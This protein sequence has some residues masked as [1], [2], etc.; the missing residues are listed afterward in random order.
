MYEM[1]VFAANKEGAGAHG[2]KPKP[3]SPEARAIAGKLPSPERPETKGDGRLEP[4]RRLGRRGPG[5]K[6]WTERPRRP[7]Q[8]G[9]TRQHHATPVHT[10]LVPQD[11]LGRLP[12]GAD[13]KKEKAASVKKN[14]RADVAE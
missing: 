6:G 12:T 10:G 1:A 4:A 8:R 14:S 7:G 2:L 13:D 11:Y 9:W 5:R 3:L